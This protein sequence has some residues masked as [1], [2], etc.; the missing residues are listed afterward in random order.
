MLITAVNIE[1][2]LDR[3]EPAQHQPRLAAL[4]SGA[5][6][7]SRGVVQIH[8]RAP[9]WGPEAVDHDREVRGNVVH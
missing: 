5:L 2:S 8:V 3:L 9:P 1:I 6:H 4:R 7:A